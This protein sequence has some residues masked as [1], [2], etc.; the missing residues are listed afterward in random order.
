MTGFRRRFHPRVY[1]EIV[2]R[3]G[4]RCADCPKKLGTDPREIEFDH[5]VPLWLGGSDAPDNLQALCKPCHRVKTSREARERAKT[6]RLEAAGGGRK[7]NKRERM[8]ARYLE[9]NNER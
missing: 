2:K 9:E 8:L 7:L 5:A 1:A 4:N 3:Q 6:K